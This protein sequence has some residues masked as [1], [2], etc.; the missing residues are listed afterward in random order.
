MR[1]L[2]AKLILGTSIGIAIILCAF[3]IVIPYVVKHVMIKQFDSALL[4]KATLLASMVEIEDGG[5]DLQFDEFDMR[6]FDAK[7]NPGY[8]QLWSAGGKTIYSSPS[9]AETGLKKFS[10]TMKRSPD[11]HW[12][13]TPDGRNGRAVT[14]F[15]H[16]S[17]EVQSGNRTEDPATF[18]I[19]L[20]RG[21]S[22]IEH[23]VGRIALLLVFIGVAVILLSC[24]MLWIMIKKNLSPLNRMAGEIEKLDEQ[25]LSSRISDEYRLKELEPVK[26]RLN[27]LLT[28]LEEAFQRE[29]T[30]SADVAHELRTPLAGLRSILDVT[31]SKERDSAEYREALT[32]NLQIAEQMQELIEKLLTLAR[33]EAGQTE[34]KI[35]DVDIAEIINGILKEMDE[36]IK[37]RK[38]GI[39]IEHKIE[40]PVQSDRFL[41]TLVIR[42]ILDN[43]VS[44]AN[45]G[46][47]ITIET[48]SGDGGAIIKVANTGCRIAQED[49]EKVFERFWQ[50][51]EA[52]SK[53]GIHCG[54]GLST[55]KKAVDI[56]KGNVSAQSSAGGEFRIE[57]SLPA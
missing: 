38:L 20:A 17:I 57:I 16:P 48:S 5:I 8:L 14:L 53:T 31:L 46:G 9:L 40:S 52:R 22:S 2:R 47:K 6:E 10:G 12:I 24:V 32:D 21:T 27:E 50:G 39:H 44:Y 49:A 54:L 55:V 15:F 30:F 1:S 4:D 13:K 42:N 26:D 18:I 36:S 37:T 7:K 56:L 23:T 19:L 25:N 43:A 51:D 11:F 3:V 41:V 34:A 29:R 35:D 45:E 33:L 28:R